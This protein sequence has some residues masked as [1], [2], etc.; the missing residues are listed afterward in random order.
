[1]NFSATISKPAPLLRSATRP[2]SK[3]PT[4][5]VHTSLDKPY[6]C[7]EGRARPWRR[8]IADDGARRSGSPAVALGGGRPESIKG[9]ELQLPEADSITAG[10]HRTQHLN[11]GEVGSLG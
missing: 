5:L 11:Y 1:M 3:I 9:G 6:L 10:A 8:L 4:C 2:L 7:P